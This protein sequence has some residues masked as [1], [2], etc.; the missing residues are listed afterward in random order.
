MKK[1][2]AYKQVCADVQ[3]A[4]EICNELDD[5]INKIGT[6]RPSFNVLV[7]RNSSDKQFIYGLGIL[8]SQETAGIELGFS[9]SE[10]QSFKDKKANLIELRKLVQELR[11]WDTYWTELR[12]YKYQL[13]K[14][15]TDEE[16]FSLLEYPAKPGEKA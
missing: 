14:I 11:A 4:K 15:L 16:K 10:L 7:E 3:T 2:E 12:D 8:M 5:R 9:E 6:V 13:E 1:L